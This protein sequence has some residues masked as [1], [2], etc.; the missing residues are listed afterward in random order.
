[1]TASFSMSPH[2]QISLSSKLWLS[3][4]NCIKK[5]VHIHEWK[6]PKHIAV[7]LGTTFVQ[8][9]AKCRIIDNKPVYHIAP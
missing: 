2:S 5:C 1:M 4:V 3:G 7:D 9:I 8:K 6:Q